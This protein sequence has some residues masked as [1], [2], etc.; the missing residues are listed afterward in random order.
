MTSAAPC[1]VVGYR[2]QLLDLGCGPAKLAADGVANGFGKPVI[3]RPEDVSV[4]DSERQHLNRGSERGPIAHLPKRSSQQDQRAR[5]V[6]RQPERVDDVRALANG[7]ARGEVDQRRGAVG[8]QV[9]ARLAQESG[10]A[11]LVESKGG[12]DGRRSWPHVA[13]QRPRPGGGFVQCSLPA[14]CTTPNTGI[15]LE[16][17]S[18]RS[19]AV[20]GIA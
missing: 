6:A 20:Q 10:Q 1:L 5:I 11:P 8:A 3:W 16:R 7:I 19:A 14:S 15:E 17:Q 13:G 9:G 18:S 2:D 4:A 12:V